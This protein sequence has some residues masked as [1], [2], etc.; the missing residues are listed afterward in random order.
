ML[1]EKDKHIELDELDLI[2][3]YG[4]PMEIA[5]IVRCKYC[6]YNF[7][8]GTDSTIAQCERDALLRNP[9]FFCAD[10]ERE[11]KHE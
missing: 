9:N 4:I 8:C 3:R 1:I 6:K 2:K 10:G 11:E 5:P 7:N